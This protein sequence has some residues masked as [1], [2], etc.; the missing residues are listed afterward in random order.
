M[1]RVSYICAHCNGYVKGTG[2]CPACEREPYFA[3]PAWDGVQ[4]G[5]ID[6]EHSGYYPPEFGFPK[7]PNNP[8][9]SIA[10]AKRRAEDNMKRADERT[11]GAL[12]WQKL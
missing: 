6:G 1:A 4:I 5:M 11:G 10:P 9:K 3:L 2:P 7:D 8:M 12:S